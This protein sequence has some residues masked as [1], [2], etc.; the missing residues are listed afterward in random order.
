M[1]ITRAERAGVGRTE[2]G[3]EEVMWSGL[4]MWSGVKK[5]NYIIEKDLKELILS[6]R[7]ENLKR[8]NS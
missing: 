7:H 4:K 5:P 1:G 3:E 2:R 8:N 6:S